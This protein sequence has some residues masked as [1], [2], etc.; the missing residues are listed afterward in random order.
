V[1][2]IL[3]VGKR[4]LMVK[5]GQLLNNGDGLSVLYKREVVGF[6][7]NTVEQLAHFELEG[8]SQRQYRLTPQ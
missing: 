3:S 6:R 4:N 1:G 7:V 5:T 2:E 8:V